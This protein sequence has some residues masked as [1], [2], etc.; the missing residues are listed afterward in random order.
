LPE[1]QERKLGSPDGNFEAT[2][3]WFQSC[4]KQHLPNIER[5][6]P[7]GKRYPQQTGVKREEEAS[8]PFLHSGAE[9]LEKLDSRQKFHAK[10]KGQP[11]VSA[12]W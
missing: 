12:G 2:T 3:R 7:K 5:N 11:C 4:D 6:G 8:K 9:V 1:K 10:K